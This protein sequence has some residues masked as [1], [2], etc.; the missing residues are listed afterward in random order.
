MPYRRPQESTTVG[1]A[2]RLFTLTLLNC[3]KPLHIDDP[4]YC[5]YAAHIARAPLDPYGFDIGTTLEGASD[6]AWHV[7]APPVF[8]CWPAAGMRLIDTRLS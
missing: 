1:L 2:G 3:P 4:F 5:A 7:V 6:P 8:L